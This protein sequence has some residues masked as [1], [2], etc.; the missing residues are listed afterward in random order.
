MRTSTKDNFV[1]SVALEVKEIRCF[2]GQLARLILYSA[3]YDY[4]CFHRIVT[5]VLLPPENR[6]SRTWYHP[7][8]SLA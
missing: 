7:T 3:Q 5:K 8:I 6:V 2:Q 1:L 4:C